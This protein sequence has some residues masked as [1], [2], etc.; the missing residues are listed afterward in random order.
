MDLSQSCDP[1]TGIDLPRADNLP[2]RFRWRVG[3][4][5]ILGGLLTLNFAALWLA[6]VI[7]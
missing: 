2:N 6:P 3:M 7:I 4:H 1:P 5:K